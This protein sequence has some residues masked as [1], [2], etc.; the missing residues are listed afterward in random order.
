MGSRSD[1]IAPKS[2]V[3]SLVLSFLTASPLGTGATVAAPAATR[4]Y[5]V[6][7][8]HLVTTD[9]TAALRDAQHRDQVPI[10]IWYPAASG[11]VERPLDIGPP[12]HPYFRSGAAA[13]NA[14]FADS[15]RRPIVLFSHGF[16]GSARMMAWFGTALARRGY[17]VVAVDH[18]G[19]NGANRMTLAGALLFWE[20][21][22]D[23]AAALS[24]LELDPAIEA[25]IDPTRLA[26]AG[27]SAGG[28]TALAAAGGRVDI[29]RFRQFCKAHPND[30]VCRPQAEFPVTSAEAKAF[31]GSP[32]MKV[33][34]RRSHRD[35][36]IAG[37]KAV[38]VMAPAI[39]QSFVP[40]SLARIHVPVSIIL[41]DAD[42]VVPPAAN[43]EAAAAMI[44]GAKIKILPGV[45]HYDF[46]AE[47]TPAGNARIPICRTGISRARTHRQAIADALSLLNQTLGTPSIRR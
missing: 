43:G 36:G 3:A 10:T 15:E 1:Q 30:G 31:L 7:E 44:P 12:G 19:N 41:G 23:L 38:F 27:F 8:R 40:A 17:L 29:K 37:V 5:P 34:R 14:P 11:A 46:L 33:E 13:P 39:V 18:P 16:G 4:A 20:R 42:K 24:R 22:A 35:L 47:C 2:L 21:P 25:H 9:R 26:V 45:G 32:A 6:G 28:F